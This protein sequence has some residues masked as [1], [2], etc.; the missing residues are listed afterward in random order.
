[1]QFLISGSAPVD[2]KILRFFDTLGVPTLEV[3]GMSEM[4]FLL[5]MNR[6]GR[7][8]YG[9]VGEPLANVEIRL[10]E[11]GEV[12]VKSEAALE[13][14]W[15]ETNTHSLYDGDGFLRTGDLGRFDHGY[16]YLTGR[17]KEI[18]KTST[19]IRVAPNMVENAYKDIPG[20]ENIVA[21]G[22]NRKYLVGLI[23][24][25]SDFLQS[26]SS[27]NK[28]AQAYVAHE[29]GLRHHRLAPNQQI[30]KFAILP[31]PFSI[32]E[33]EITPTLKLRR[34]A[35]EEKYAPLIDSLYEDG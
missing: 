29:L 35:I 11:D 6:P 18:I 12:L 3:Y 9:S 30:K 25:A 28:N 23:C 5:T 34:A 16:L 1:M 24:L 22:N 15:G 33:G 32:D 21:I 26:L 27:T 14:Y 13:H 17:K 20:V 4:G 19:G 31:Q 10:A 7:I 8:R 2:E